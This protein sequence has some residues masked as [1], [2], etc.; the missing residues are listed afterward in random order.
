MKI[1]RYG[2]RWNIELR[3]H[4]ASNSDVKCFRCGEANTV[5]RGEYGM[6]ETLV[7]LREIK[8]GSI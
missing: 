7:I 1:N 8:G 4:N 3:R 5:R 6:E 2:D